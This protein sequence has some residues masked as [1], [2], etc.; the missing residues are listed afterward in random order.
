M[1]KRRLDETESKFAN[2]N[3]TIMVE[4]IEYR[5]KVE[6]AK[7]QFVLDTAEL[8]VKRQLK[9]TE[10]KKK[11]IEKD[12]EELKRNVRIL[13][14]QIRNGVTIKKK[15]KEDGDKQTTLKDFDAK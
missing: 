3:L 15:Q 12:V 7:I 11:Q 14:N 5:E 9:E 13:R 1:T 2:Q 4:E 8:S 10:M 6:L